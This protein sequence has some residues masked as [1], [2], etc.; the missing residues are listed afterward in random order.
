MAAPRL[1]SGKRPQERLTPRELECL[2]LLVEG[3]GRFTG[4]KRL[5]VSSHT[6]G[7]HLRR[8]Y[9]KLGVNRKSEAIAWWNARYGPEVEFRRLEVKLAYAER[10]IELFGVDFRRA[11]HLEAGRLMRKFIDARKS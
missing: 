1:S 5:G 6:V 11:V 3:M 7:M 4:A 10:V 2:G 8:A 9:A